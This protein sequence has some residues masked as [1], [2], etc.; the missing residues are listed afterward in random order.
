ME[1]FLQMAGHQHTCSVSSKSFS[2]LKGV[3]AECEIQRFET[4]LQPT[5]EVMKE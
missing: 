2:V 3:F 1:A 5:T 4:F